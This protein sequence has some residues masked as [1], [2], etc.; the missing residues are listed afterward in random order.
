MYDLAVIGSGAAG[1][2]AAK[3]A[4]QAGLKTVLI[5]KNND[6]L[7]GTCVN[8]GCIPAKFF[9]NGVRHGKRW[10]EIFSAKA[11][12]LAKIKEPLYKHLIAGGLQVAYGSA[13]FIDKDTIVVKGQA[14]KAKNFIIAAG[15][16]PKRI[17][18]GDNVIFAEDVFALK[19]IPDKILVI[20]GGYIGVEMASLFCACGSAVTLIEKE[21]RILLGFDGRLANR[22]R[23]ILETKGIKI[24]TGKTI[25]DYNL[26]DFG[27]VVMGVGR[28]PATA[29]L[30][31]DKAFVD[32]DARG[33]IKVDKYFR[34]SMEHIYACGDVTGR[35]MLAYTGEYQADLCVKNITRGFPASPQE[36][37]YSGIAYCVFGI[38][39]IARTGI[40]EEEAKAGNIKYRVIKSNFLKFS[41]AYVYDDND[42]FIQI[43]VGED[44]VILGADIISNRA[45]DL[46]GIL[47]LCVKNHLKIDAIKDCL[48]VHPSL[49]E[50]IPALLREDHR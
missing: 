50:I 36:E 8:R 46:I 42:G 12:L 19:S 38:P 14:I 30:G 35:Y 44:D 9:I 43:L 34:T 20:G 15:S 23:I 21:E 32:V 2:A 37:N 1:I 31:L 25:S 10:E 49:S 16:C 41:A 33:W 22:Y 27:L 45:V 5:E 4:M 29:G 11:A 39:Q 6:A 47:T 28:E 48:L 24:E 40:S 17:A 7:G 26:K 3:A 18:Q 13:E